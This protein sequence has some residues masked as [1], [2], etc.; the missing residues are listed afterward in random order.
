M[1]L[2]TSI[3]IPN[4]KCHTCGTDIYRRPSQIE[5]GLVYCSRVCSGKSKRKL[6]RCPVC[7]REY[8]GP[9]LSCSKGCSN[10]IRSREGE[11][12]VYGGNR[13]LLKKV[14]YATTNDIWE[15]ERCGYDN[16]VILHLHHVIRRSNGG[17]DSFDN[18]ELLCPN[19]HYTH[20]Q[21]DC[22]DNPQM[23]IDIRSMI[24]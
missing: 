5:K 12:M 22:R 15:C 20:H 10:V 9:S 24:T 3:R 2:R 19:C 6:K 11:T 1:T 23:M 21:G 8:T 16:F 17:C 14:Q 4:C 7:E 13:T 18:L